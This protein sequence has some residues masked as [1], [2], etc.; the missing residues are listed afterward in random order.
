MI[1][2]RFADI[3]LAVV[4]GAAISLVSN[5]SFPSVTTYWIPCI[6]DAS[7]SCEPSKTDVNEKAYGL[8]F[9]SREAKYCG[10]NEDCVRTVSYTNHPEKFILNTLAW[11]IV[12]YSGIWLAGK[13]SRA[14][15]RH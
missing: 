3:A 2:S 8:P 11:S 5:F 7:Q 1:A 12:M 10:P 4:I 14:N 15:P 13:L 9:T 6:T